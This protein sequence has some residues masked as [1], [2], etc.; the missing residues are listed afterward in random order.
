MQTCEKGLAEL[1]S[2]SNGTGRIPTGAYRKIE[3]WRPH[4][5]KNAK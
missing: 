5:G 1:F 2:Q 4:L 3:L